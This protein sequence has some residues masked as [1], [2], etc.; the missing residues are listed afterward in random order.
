MKR[1]AILIMV[2]AAVLG[3]AC[4]VLGMWSGKRNSRRLV[5]SL[6]W[7]VR[8]ARREG[9]SGQRRAADSMWLALVYLQRD[10]DIGHACRELNNGIDRLLVLQTFEMRQ[11]VQD[12]P[13]ALTFEPYERPWFQ[14]AYNVRRHRE[15][16][17]VE[18]ESAKWEAQI[19]SVLETKGPVPV[20]EKDDRA[21][22][23]G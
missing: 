17:P 13:A 7:E 6:Q 18:Y 15:K 11:G 2:G 8:S 23:R 21:T 22:G 1:N 3:V 5:E 4:F 10:H 19:R 12:P 20:T 9:S 16:Y 14:T